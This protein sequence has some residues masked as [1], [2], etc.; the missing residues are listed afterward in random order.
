M[1]PV[2]ADSRTDDASS[3]HLVRYHRRRWHGNKPVVLCVNKCENVAEQL[4]MASPFWAMG[5]EPIPVSAISGSGS[6]ELLDAVVEALPPPKDQ[7]EEEARRAIRVAIVGRP[8]AGKSSLLNAIVGRERSI[9]S[10]LAG[11]TR[12]AIDTEFTGPDGTPFVLV[13]TAGIRRRTSVAASKVRGEGRSGARGM[14]AAAVMEEESGTGGKREQRAVGESSNRGSPD[15]D[16]N[17]PRRP[18][19]TP[20]VALADRPQTST[21]TGSAPFRR[22]DRGQAA[23]M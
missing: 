5:I 7:G 12:D 21:S 3:L 17:I 18:L 11:T 22:E 1:T 10:D 16:L 4:V 19:G 23:W 15:S 14:G 6:G 8:N 2:R 20:N 13:D 9:V